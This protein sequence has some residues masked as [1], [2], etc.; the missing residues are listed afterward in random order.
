[1]EWSPTTRNALYGGLDKTK[2]RSYKDLIYQALSDAADRTMS[3]QEMYDWVEK[4]GN[5]A[6]R[7]S[8]VWKNGIQKAFRDDKVWLCKLYAINTDDGAGIS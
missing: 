3:L 5:T 4:T 7:P 2:P 1:M 6:G 8:K